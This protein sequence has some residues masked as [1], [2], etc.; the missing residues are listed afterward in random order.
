MP[1]ALAN[2]V[3]ESIGIGGR[4][5]GMGGV[6]IGIAT[7]TSAMVTNP[8]GITQIEGSR[9]DFGH[10]LFFPWMRYKNKNNSF[11]TSSWG[12][13]HDPVFNYLPQWGWVKN[14]SD[15]PFSLG[16]GLFTV[17]GGGS[18]FHWK[19]DYF[20]QQQEVG[21]G[22]AFNKITPTIAYQLNSKLS[23]GLALNI[24]YV[25]LELKILN[26]PAYV[27]IKKASSWG[28]GYA[29]GFLYQATDKLKIGVAYTSESMLEDVETDE[30]YATIAGDIERRYT[31]T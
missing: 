10:G 24:Y 18:R 23:I 15:R 22:L 3:A 29:V 16:I 5:L 25:P 19:N 17:A 27:K 8:A 21:S 7:D 4:S 6:D 9:L 28:G 31:H 2:N 1:L 14:L 11:R 30:G 12:Y 20:T 13:C 26:G